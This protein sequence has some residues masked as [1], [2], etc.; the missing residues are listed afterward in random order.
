M[1]TKSCNILF[2]SILCFFVFNLNA[3]NRLNV[4]NFKT[5]PST[6]KVHTWWHWMNNGIT[7]DGI[8]KDLES[9][10]RQGVVQATIL[11][12]GL[13][14][15]K[16]LE[17]KPV[18]FGTPEWYDMFRWSLKEANRLGIAVGIH[19]CDGWST[20][21]GPWVTHQESMKMYV[22]SKTEMKGGNEISV[23][24]PAPLGN[25]GFFRD[26]AVVAFPL[27][28][29]ENTFKSAKATITK[30]KVTTPVLHDGNPFSS[31]IVKTGDELNFS[32]NS[33]LNT[34][35]IAFYSH[36]IDGHWEWKWGDASQVTSSYILSISDDGNR[37][38]KVANVNFTG[39]NKMNYVT[40]PTVNSKFIKL[41]C[42]KS[43]INYPLAEIEF[44]KDGE[45]ATF[46]PKIKNLLSKTQYI[47]V[48]T[49][50]EYELTP[51]NQAKG[52][53]ETSIIDISAYMSADG[54]LTWKAPVG[55]WGVIRFGYTTNG[56]KNGPA[57]E[58][59]QGLEVDK[60]D[61]THL[62]KHFNSFSKIL[63]DKAGAYAGNTFK[64]LLIDSW[65]ADFQNW[66]DRFPEEF[67]KRRGYDITPWIPVLCGE[68]VENTKLSEGFLYDFRLTISDLVGDNY[69]K[70]FRD[71]CHRNK[72]EMHAEVI[73]GNKGHYPQ[74]D[75]LKSNSYVDMPMM[76][77]W[78]RQNSDQLLQYTPTAVP[79][80]FLPVYAA[81]D[82]NKNVIGCEAYTGFSHYS[83]SPFDLKPFGDNAY[84]GG[85]NQ[86][87]LH[88]YVHQPH[89]KKPGVTLWQFGSHFNRNNPWWNYAQDWMT[90]QSRVQYMLQQGQPAVD[91]V[92]YIG[93]Q[94]P[95]SVTYKSFINEIP[96]GFIGYPCNLEML[97]DKA[98][99]IDGKLSF[100]GTQKYALLALP[101][102][103]NME[104]ATLRRIAELV[105]DGLIIYGPKP[106]EM[107]GLQELKNSGVEFSKLC[108]KLWGK[109]TDNAF[110][111]NKYGKG[112]VVWGKTF[113]TLLNDLSI[114][115]GFTSNLFKATDLMHIH[116][117]IG[118]NEVYFVFNQQNR[119][120]NRE[121]IFRVNGKTPEIWNAEDGTVVQ[122]AIY[123]V[124]GKQTRIPVSFKPYQS[125]FFVFKNAELNNFINKVTLDGRQIFPMIQTADSMLKIPEATYKDS[126]FKVSAS[127]TGNYEL[128]TNNGKSINRV[129]NVPAEFQIKDFK[130]S[131]SF[132]PITNDMIKPVEISNLKSLSDYSDPAIKYFAGSA[133]YKIL[134]E[135]PR[136]FIST[137]DSVYL[138]LGNMDAT[139]EVRLNGKILA[140][141]WTPYSKISV[142]KLL[143]KNNILEISV[144]VVCRNRIIGDYN[145][146]GSV[147]S[148][149]TTATTDTYFKKGMPLKPSG[150]IGPLKVVKVN[151]SSN[152]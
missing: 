146:F 59:G 14:I 108:D 69:Y 109:G 134:F 87:I 54:K 70:H 122:P 52:I 128:G 98:T 15:T 62:N 120:L 65:E 25:N 60:M 104:L 40:I 27:S 142:S 116:K 53:S 131:V 100:G 7:K 30:N 63:I 115:P 137:N 37:Y 49:E 95:Q 38:T 110:V 1:K 152:K 68:L 22:W 24:L 66:T 111:E 73:Y 96:D 41:T 140:Y 76:E 23:Q 88:S 105:H 138:E 149:W 79:R 86:M 117:I 133:Q 3:E 114:V 129:L 143:K 36:I 19:N 119:P 77:F 136:T 118:D 78:A 31:V 64:F 11:N 35:K 74:I 9:M 94:L 89:D 10:K 148:F 55:Q 33:K 26:V 75:V 5:P 67:K 20:S 48:T 61:T 130:G 50:A 12:I 93:D 147:K 21:G 91:F 84:C 132:S 151:A 141:V 139:A 121:L 71:L 123:S 58:K 92:F 42:V 2:A 97:I 82:G 112:K 45:T 8:T 107:L 127:K 46:T 83:E 144:A 4:T 29:E 103:P 13:P 17:V 81:L 124:E 145:E 80:P 56:K 135:A 113:K 34:T 72:M 16:S 101:D 39:I 125:F 47:G 43:P 102:K 6:S 32:M 44:L 51:A 126:K 57:T 18:Y 85:V 28:S 106:T 90:Y 150:L 99:L